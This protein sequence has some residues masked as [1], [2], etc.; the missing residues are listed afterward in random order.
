MARIGV[1]MM[2]LKEHVEQLG[3]FEVLRRLQEIGFRSVE[4]SQIPMTPENVAEMARAREELGMEFAAMSAVVGAA[5]TAANDSLSENY[6]KV[7]ADARKLG[8]DKIRIGM[9]PFEAMRSAEALAE[10]CA[11]AEEIAQRLQQEGITLYY[12]NHHLEFARV[13]GELILDRIRAG[14]PTMRLEIDVHW[15][16]R[17]GKDPARTLSQYAGLV[18]LVHLKD[19]RIAPSVPD[20]AFEALAAGDGAGFMASF[21]GPEVIQFAEIGEGNLDWAEVI[22]AAEESGAQHM[23]IEQDAQY[24]RDPFEALRISHRNLSQMGF[25]DR[26]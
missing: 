12:H 6:D 18:D 23:L 9:M 10:F 24:G 26:F 15:V 5:L 11:E 17:G 14:A 21:V 1:Q 16:Q 19:Y 8:T 2:M 7:V 13:D 22:A 3:P 25:A 20:S 4:V